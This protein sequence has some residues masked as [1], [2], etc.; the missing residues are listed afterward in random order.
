[1]DL[2]QAAAKGSASHHVTSPGLDGHAVQP[3][4]DAGVMVDE[5]R[6]GLGSCHTLRERADHVVW[7]Q[8]LRDDAGE[9]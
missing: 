1:V 8:A 2:D 3:W 5:R 6:L 9:G 7:H 4:L